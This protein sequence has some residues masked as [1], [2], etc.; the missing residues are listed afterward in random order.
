MIA[1]PPRCTRT[2]TLFPYPTL[3]RSDM[4]PALQTRLL[5]VLAEDEVF[6]VGV[7]ELSRVDV[8]VVAATHQDLEARVADGR[9]RSDLLH[10][11]DVV[12][13]HLPPLRERRGDVP[14][15]AERFLQAA[16]VRFDAPPK[17]FGKAALERLQN[18]DWPGNVREL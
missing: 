15:L 8:R 18:H 9:F 3:V 4:P 17:R 12:R 5:R 1:L 14:K 13:L 10:R 6:R 11:L 7:R 16:A 2:D